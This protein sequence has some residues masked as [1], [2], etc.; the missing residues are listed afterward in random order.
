MNTQKNDPLQSGQSP[1]IEEW[2]KVLYDSY[3]SSGQAQVLRTEGKLSL[4]HRRPYLMKVVQR[5]IPTDL[6]ARIMDFGCGM[7]GL[8]VVLKEMGYRNISGVDVSPEMVEAASELGA[9][10]VTLRELFPTLTD[11]QDESLDAAVFMDVLEHMTRAELFAILTQVHRVL[12]PGGRLVAHVPNAS[13]ILGSTIRY[14]DLTHEIAFSPTSW[15]Q[16][17]RCLG[18]H[19]PMCF[20]DRP[21]VHGAKSL[22]RSILWQI[23][24]IPWVLTTLAETG[25]VR[26]ILSQN[27]LCYAAKAPN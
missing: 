5:T 1:S 21:V 10:N 3:V 14:G 19:E 24:R 12:K 8:L 15:S 27:M 23:V 20:E 26:P 7:G 13:G 4:E 16:I 22:A 6:N 9:P 2:R 11:L 25:D 18:F 17:T